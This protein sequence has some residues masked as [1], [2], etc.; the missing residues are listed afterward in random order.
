MAS[1]V[2]KSGGQ[3]QNSKDSPRSDK[4]P[5]SSPFVGISSFPAPPGPPGT[6]VFGA[7]TYI[8]NN[9]WQTDQ[10]NKLDFI[11]QKL[12]KIEQNQDSFLTRLG[13]IENKLTQTDIKVV[14]TENSQS[15][16]SSKYDTID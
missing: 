12:T 5:A 15:H 3:E 14:E 7:S 10:A 2:S 8:P 1:N 9:P 13:V 16:L 11:L 6:A 4:P